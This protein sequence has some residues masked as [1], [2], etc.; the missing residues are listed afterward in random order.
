MTAPATA[1]EIR[2]VNTRYHDGAAAS[3]DAK[4]GIDWGQIGRT[5]VLG[6]VR[7]ALGGQLGHFPRSLEIGAGTGYFSLHLLQAGIV[8]QAT[9]TDISPGM[10]SVLEGN[11]ARLG[12]DVETAVCDAER[13]P[14]PDE[15]FDLVLGHAVLHHLP[16]LD[17]AF[18]E[19][20]RVLRPGGRVVFAGEPSRVGD[21]IADVPKRA[22]AR[23]A[24]V[25]RAAMRAEPAEEGHSDGGAEN[26]QLES[27]VDVHAFVPDDLARWPREAGFA[28]VKVRGEELLANWFGWANRALESTADPE[29]VPFAWKLYAYRGYIGLQHVD[30]LLLEPRLPPAIFYNLMVSATKAG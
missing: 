3:Y 5:Q 25:W 12:L 11:A 13:L 22:A 14:F 10:V 16:H 17:Q 29:T 8:G 2:D 23:V 6:K 15:S 9:A 24:P 20:L 21:R 28:D 27:Q 30:R 18:S 26:H 19:F 1:E 4:W 7:K